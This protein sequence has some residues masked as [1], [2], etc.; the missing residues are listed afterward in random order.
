MRG[1]GDPGRNLRASLAEAMTKGG[2]SDSSLATSSSAVTSNRS[3]WGLIWCPPE[4]FYLHRGGEE[5]ALWRPLGD[6]VR[7][8]EMVMEP[9]L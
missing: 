9:R 1:K 8:L 6:M 5:Q 7:A 2:C 4:E 3:V